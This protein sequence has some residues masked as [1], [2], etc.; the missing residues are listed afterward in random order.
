MLAPY[1]PAEP[2]TCPVR[3]DIVA[4]RARPK[5]M[6]PGPLRVRPVKPDGDNVRKL[7]LDAMTP[8]WWTDD[9]IVVAG[10][11]L[12]VYAETAEAWLGVRVSVLR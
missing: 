4:A 7:V 9:K 12:S 1:A 5:R 11:T 8:T 2:M 10:D 6:A 3:V